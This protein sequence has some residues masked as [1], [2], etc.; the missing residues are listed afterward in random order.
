M[1]QEEFL[2]RKLASE[3]LMPDN[4]VTSGWRLVQVSS[5]TRNMLLVADYLNLAASSAAV[6]IDQPLLVLVIPTCRIRY[7]I[8]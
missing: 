4:F 8:R 3:S 6:D 5:T 1:A 2:A 7:M